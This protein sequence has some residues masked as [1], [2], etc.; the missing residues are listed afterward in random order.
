MA[1]EVINVGT[2]A[3]DGSGD[4]L[5]DSQIKANNNFEELYNIINSQL[6]VDYGNLAVLT[7]GIQGGV[8]NTGGATK[9]VNDIVFGRVSPT[10]FWKYAI[11]NGGDPDDLA[12]YSL[13][14]EIPL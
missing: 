9:E 13:L 8:P 1:R 7:K 6:P 10:S 3:N 14:E 12:S 11:Y 2:T 4:T 5:R